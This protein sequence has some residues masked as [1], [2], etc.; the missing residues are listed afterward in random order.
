MRGVHGVRHVALQ[1]AGLLQSS[2]NPETAVGCTVALIAKK[3][4]TLHEARVNGM[5]D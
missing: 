3:K 4:K 2:A 1:E 5:T